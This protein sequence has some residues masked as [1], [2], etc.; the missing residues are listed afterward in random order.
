LSQPDSCYG[1]CATG[2]ELL[3]MQMVYAV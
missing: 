3:A 2:D 1:V